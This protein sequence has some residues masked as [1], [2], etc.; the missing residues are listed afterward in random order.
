MI[1]VR[2]V[3]SFPSLLALTC[4]RCLPLDRWKSLQLGV[5]TIW[6]VCSRSANMERCAVESGIAAKLLDVMNRAAWP[7]SLRD[8]AGG[9]LEFLSERHSNLRWVG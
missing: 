3:R 9:C 5:L 1:L 2:E 7:P 4:Y 6:N 8:M